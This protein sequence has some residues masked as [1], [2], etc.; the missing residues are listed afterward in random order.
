MRRTILN[1]FQKPWIYLIVTILGMVLKFHNLNHKIFWE[2]EIYTVQHVVGARNILEIGPGMENEIVN[3]SHYRALLKHASTELTIGEELRAQFGTMNLNPLH[4]V[5]LSFWYRLAGDD[6]VHYRL[7][8]VLI[9]ILTLP[10]LFFLARKLFRSD[11]V[12][13]ITTS[14]YSVSPF[15][16][17]FAQEARYYIF[18]AF[19]LV[20]LHFFLIYALDKKKLLWW[21]GY[22]LAGILALYCSILSGLILFEHLL[23]ILILYRKE[24][25]KF[26]GSGMVML[27]AY[28]PWLL[29]ILNRQQEVVSSLEW[30][31]MPER[32]PVWAPILGITLGYVRTFSF[33]KE[34]TLYWDD[35]FGNI[36]Y[37]LVVETF[38]NL[39]ILAF[40]ILA[41]IKMR[42]FP[43]KES[44]VFI[45]LIFIPGFILFYF[46]DLFRNAVTSIW[47][48]YHIFAT[49]P[50]ILIASS[51]FVER[52]QTKKTAALLIYCG[53]VVISLYSI[54]TISRQK[55]WY[56]GGE[57]VLEYV[58]NAEL[59]SN[60]EKALVITDFT[61]ADN[62]WT[63]P[64]LTMQV[65]L[66]CTS[67]QIDVLR[68]G[69]DVPDMCAL[70][71]EGTYSDIFVLYPSSRLVEALTGQFGD[72]MQIL[73]GRRGPPTWIIQQAA[74]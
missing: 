62:P 21:A 51:Y 6:I 20:V 24:F 5:F 64:T 17:V 66:N 29:L 58:Q 48:R 18:W 74:I 44:A 52:V 9:F 53:L 55:Y 69:E 36:T 41:L 13:W 40:L 54:H 22:A 37:D 4:Y 67:E 70:I 10:F 61:R 60:A 73:E 14:L 71:P 63:G 26:A 68:I 30:H 12:A 11:L 59:L 49:I 56:L 34:Y 28:L 3:L 16:H 31:K 2:D 35:V 38:F 57:W 32:M 42:T 72:R 15:I 27:L 8:S 33:Y 19:T 45:L 43:I 25:W 23:F 46:L 50:V 39:C 7:F 47:W 65:L 1:Q